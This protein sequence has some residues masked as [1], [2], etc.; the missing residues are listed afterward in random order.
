MKV[1]HGRAEGVPS[2]QRG[3]TFTGAVWADPVMPTTDSVTINNVFFSPGAR[4]FWHTHEYGQVL[5]VTAGK[6]W[7]CLEGQ[8]PQM[9]RQGDVVWIGP[10]E[11]HWHGAAA[12]TYM[13]HMATSLGGANWQ[14]A[15]AD[16]DY[17]SQR[18]ASAA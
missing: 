11:R 3:S 5:Q 18:A 2:E 13:I 9:I 16:K 17:P 7:I 6:G 4:T 8:E 14:E 1:F 10:N 12:D 15:V